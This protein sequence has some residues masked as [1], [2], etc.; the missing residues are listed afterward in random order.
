[1]EISGYLLDQSF[2]DRAHD[3]GSLQANFEDFVMGDNRLRWVVDDLPFE[4][5]ERKKNN[6]KQSFKIIRG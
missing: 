6:G 1:M 5:G 3:L 4:L 2:D